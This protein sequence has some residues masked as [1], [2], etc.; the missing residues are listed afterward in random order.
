MNKKPL[1][2]QAYALFILACLSQAQVVGQTTPAGQMTAGQ[3]TPAD[4]RE[5]ILKHRELAL[6]NEQCCGIPASITLAQAIIESDRGNS[7]LAREANNHFGI[8][9]HTKDWT[10]PGYYK[11]DDAPNECFRKYESVQESYSDHAQFL[12]SR[13]RYA[14]LFTLP[15]N[16]Y[17]A[18]AQGLK[19]AG[20]ATNPEYAQKLIKCIEE[21][22]LHQI[23][24]PDHPYVQAARTGTVARPVEVRTKNWPWDFPASPCQEGEFRYNYTRT[25][26]AQAGDDLLAIASRH[27]VELWKLLVYNGYSEN[28]GLAAGQ[29][30]FLQKRMKKAVVERHTMATGQRVADV[31]RYYCVRE[32]SLRLKNNLMAG[33]EV[34]AGQTLSLRKNVRTRLQTT[35]LEEIER[36]RKQHTSG[37][38]GVSIPKADP[39][40]AEAERM[41][42]EAPVEE[43]Y[44]RVLTQETLYSLARRYKVKVEDLKK[45]NNL[46][47]DHIKIGQ[48]LRVKSPM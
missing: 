26:C 23:A 36:I 2:A 19:D 46:P 13:P 3:T 42:M 10:G 11:D 8:K 12:R 27:K 45:W 48:I 22:Q 41:R 44:H 34:V 31:A 29:K 40:A 28:V 9:C 33:E 32:K 37:Q 30:I 25:V 35:T 20:Y 15:A 14:N 39:G 4:A 43:G 47:D 1:M 38:T 24:G 18:W 21:H 7:Q 16:N 6:K 17:A 5:Y